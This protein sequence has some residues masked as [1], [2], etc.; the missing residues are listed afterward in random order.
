MKL[1]KS[2]LLCLGVFIS[3]CSHA[4][5]REI[6]SSD[7]MKDLKK[8]KSITVV[9][10]IILDDVNFSSTENYQIVGT[11]IQNVIEGNVCFLNCIFM[12]DV[13]AGSVYEKLPVS[14]RFNNNL[15]FTNCDFRGNVSFDNAV[16]M[17][18]VNFN[19]AKFLKPTSF[20]NLMA[21][22]KDSYFSEIEAES[23]VVFDYASFAGNF[24]CMDGKFKE[25]FSLQN[26]SINGKLMA[27]GLLCSKLAEFDGISVR[28]SSLFNYSKFEIM[29]SFIKARFYDDVSFV[30]VQVPDDG[31]FLKDSEA[32]FFGKLMYKDSVTPSK[33]ELK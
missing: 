21:W 18:T 17:G 7:F 11:Q 29:P 16:V 10:K 1:Y 23:H 25:I 9:N 12:G 30:D 31:D 8:G 14:T 19:K 26:V 15:V 33:V 20:I 27:N 5:Q 22:A 32:Y 6:K 3:S 28:Q 2:L 4:E 13:M 24:Y